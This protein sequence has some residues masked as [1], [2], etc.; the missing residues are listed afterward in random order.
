MYK[1]TDWGMVTGDVLSVM[2][3]V[4]WF[5]CSV[6]RTGRGAE[7]LSQ[8]ESATPER[9]CTRDV[10]NEA[11]RCPKCSWGSVVRTGR[12]IGKPLAERERCTGTVL[13]KGVQNE[14]A[15]CPKWFGVV[16]SVPDGDRKT[17]R[18]ARALH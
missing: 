5:C 10:Q 2:C 6:V 3:Y 11:D 15:R 14:G 7:Y 4:L 9:F 17:S 1:R 16:P 13:H 12:G 8:S 18:R